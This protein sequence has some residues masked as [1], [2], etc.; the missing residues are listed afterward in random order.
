MLKLFLWPLAIWLALTRRLRSGRSLSPF[1]LA[2][3]LVSWAAIGFAGIGDYPG[4]LRSLANDESTSSY[5]VVALG[6]RAHLPLVAA[7]VVAVL[8]TLALLAAAAG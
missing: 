2:L 1:A 8:V 5:S 6:V 4:I 7:R 3:A